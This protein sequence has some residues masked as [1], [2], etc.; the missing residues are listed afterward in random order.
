MRA[1][2]IFRT[3]AFRIVLVY[4]VLFTISAAALV[5]FAY[6]NTE[7]ALNSGTDQTVSSEIDELSDLYEGAGLTGLTD[8]VLN[9]SVRGGQNLYFLT[10]SERSSDRR[11]SRS[12]AVD[13]TDI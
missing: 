12:P 3:I 5:A 7:R 10:D 11:Q 13:R 9:R 8:V 6:W 4:V 1:P 2:N